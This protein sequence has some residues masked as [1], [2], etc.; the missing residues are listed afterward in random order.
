MTVRIGD[1]VVVIDGH[2][3]ETRFPDGTVCKGYPEDTDAYRQIAKDLGYDDDTGRL[4]VAHEVAHSLLAAARGL[5]HSPILWG[6]AHDEENQVMA[7]QRYAN[8]GPRPAGDLDW[9]ALKTRLLEVIG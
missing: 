7:L 4:S 3:T 2:Y 9:D 6:I 1:A 5:P 8:G